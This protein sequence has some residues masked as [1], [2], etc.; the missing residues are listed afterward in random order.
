M[1]TLD[2]MRQGLKG[3]YPDR[4]GP[5]PLRPYVEPFHRALARHI[6]PGLTVLDVGSGRRV[7]VSDRPEDWTY[8]GLDIDRTELDRASGYDA[9]VV[10]DITEHDPSLDGRFDL[11]ISRFLLEHVKPIDRALANVHRYLRPGG[12]MV[13]IVPGRHAPFAVVNRLLPSHAGKR[14]LA[15]VFG[16]NP[17]T[18]F[19]AFYDR[20]SYTGLG[21]LLDDWTEVQIEPLFTSAQYARF[22]RP[23]QA[24]YLGYEEWSQ[25]RPNLAA[26]YVI[27]ARR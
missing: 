4:Y 24:L 17:G 1:G 9:S 27:S 2:A 11:V 12:W 5:Q 18:V 16:R 19:P 25:R 6:R 10:G 20:C 14:V 22:A 7:A 15:R 8:I 26:Y 13:S 21:R 3:G 23:F